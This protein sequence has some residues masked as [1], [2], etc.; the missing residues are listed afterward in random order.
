MYAYPQRRKYPLNQ[1]WQVHAAIAHFN[2]NAERYPPHVRRE[3]A[4]RIRERAEHFG[5]ETP[6]LDPYVGKGGETVARRHHPPK[7]K[8]PPQLRPYLFQ[9]GHRAGNRRRRRSHRR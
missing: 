7:G 3:I 6:S 1:R 9:K 4:R 8:V 2:A 5:I